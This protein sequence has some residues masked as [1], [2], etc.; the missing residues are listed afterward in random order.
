METLGLIVPDFLKLFLLFEFN[1]FLCF[2]KQ[3]K[4]RTKCVLSVF[5]FLAYLVTVFKNCFLFSKTK[6]TR[7][8]VYHILFI[9]FL[10]CFDKHK[11]TKFK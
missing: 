11:N 1:I 6:I 4:L 10:F 3:K 7:K 5:F 2:S 9:G 8:I